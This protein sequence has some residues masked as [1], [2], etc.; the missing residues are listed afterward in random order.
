MTLLSQAMTESRQK[1]LDSARQQY[2]ARMDASQREYKQMIADIESVFG[3]AA[4]ESST[5]ESTGIT[6]A[7]Q[8]Q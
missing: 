3:V 5:T 4:A 7:A 2:E 6:H 1:L 8:P